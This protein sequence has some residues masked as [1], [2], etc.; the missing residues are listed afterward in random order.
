M[1]VH[2]MSQEKC[3]FTLAIRLPDWQP[4]IGAFY[5]EEHCKWKAIAISSI[6]S[7]FPHFSSVQ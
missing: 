4:L 5:L 2:F 1:C 7:V 3:N 6:L